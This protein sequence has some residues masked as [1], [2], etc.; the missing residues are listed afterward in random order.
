MDEALMEK[1]Y[2]RGV[3]LLYSDLDPEQKVK[4]LRERLRREFGEKAMR[5]FESWLGYKDVRVTA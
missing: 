2:R 3:E 1:M 5:D 4:E